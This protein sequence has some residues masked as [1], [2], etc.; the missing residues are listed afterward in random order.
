[1]LADY[2]QAVGGRDAWKRLRSMHAKRSLTVSGQG[3][4]GSEEHWATADGKN[5]GESTLTGVGS[6]QQGFDGRVAWSKDPIFGLRKLEG[7]ELEDARIN[8]AWNAE[9]DLARLYVNVT[10]VPPPKN[11]DASL[12]C[13]ELKRK[14]GSPSVLCFDPKTH[15]RAQQTGVQPSPGGEIPYKIEFGDWREIDGIKTWFEE[16]MTAGPSTIEARITSLKFDEKLSASK[17]R[18]PKR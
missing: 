5:L 11:A 8:G 3:A 6:F 18:M 14:V 2:A 7:A 9:T 16:K 1:V 15:L 4:S 13:V 17:F 12:E 10:S